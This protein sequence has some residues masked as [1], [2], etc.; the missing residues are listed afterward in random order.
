ML[1]YSLKTF[2]DVG[3]T[4]GKLLNFCFIWQHKTSC[5]LIHV[6]IQFQ[7]IIGYAYPGLQV[8]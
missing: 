4:F 6:D 7:H 1:K 2:T 5:S 3:S 8:C